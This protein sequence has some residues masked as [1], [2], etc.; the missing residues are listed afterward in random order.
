MMVNGVRNSWLM[1][2]KNRDLAA[3]SS[4][5][6]PPPLTAIHP[7]PPRHP[8]RNASSKLDQIHPTTQTHETEIPP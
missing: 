7:P 2:A 5:C 8:R 6:S 1:F 4:T 3:S